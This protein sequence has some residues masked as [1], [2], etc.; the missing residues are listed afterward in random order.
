MPVYGSHPTRFAGL[1][2]D[3]L[4]MGF[5]P[6]T[7]S[8]LTDE[9]RLNLLQEAVN[10]SA[11]AHGEIGSCQVIWDD[12]LQDGVLGSQGNGIIRINPAYYSKDSY[13]PLPNLS[14]S[15]HCQSWSALE[16]VFHEDEHAFQEQAIDGT[17]QI[18]DQELLKQYRSN[19]FD[20]ATVDTVTGKR[21]GLQYISV[22]SNDRRDYLMYYLQSTERDAHRFS[23]EKV[24][25]IMERQQDLSHA[26]T[27]I[28]P[29]I[30][31]VDDYATRI[32]QEFLSANSYENICREA[33]EAFFTEDFEHD[34]NTSL[35][36]SKYGENNPL[37]DPSIQGIVQAAM[38]QSYWHQQEVI[39]TRQT[40]AKDHSA[41]ESEAHLGY[42]WANQSTRPRL[43]KGR[44][45]S[46]GGAEETEVMNL[47][48]VPMSKEDYAEYG[49]YMFCRETMQRPQVEQD[50][51]WGH[52][53][54]MRYAAGAGDENKYI[55][56]RERFL[57][58]DWDC[59]QRALAMDRDADRFSRVFMA[60]EM[61][62][63]ASHSTDSEESHLRMTSSETAD[64]DSARGRAVNEAW[65]READRVREGR[66]TWDWTVEQQAEMLSRSHT[67]NPGVSGFEGSHMLSVKDY[68]EHAGNPDNIQLI[69]SIAHY[70]GVHGR[71]PRANTP[72]GIYN[73]DTGE[74]TPI[75]DGRIPELPVFDLTDR[76][77][78]DQQEFHDAH[79]E[80]EQSGEGRNQGFRETKARHP[81]K[82]IG[83]HSAVGPEAT[84]ET[85]AHRGS[86]TEAQ[87]SAENEHGSGIETEKGQEEP[88]RPQLGD[89]RAPNESVNSAF[90]FE[91]V[92]RTTDADHS[93]N[94][95]FTFT[96]G[97]GAGT[98]VRDDGPAFSTFAFGSSSEGKAKGQSPE[99]VFS[100]NVER[101]ENATE[102]KSTK[103]AFAFEEGRPDAAPK[104]QGSEEGFHFETS[105]H[106]T[107]PEHTLDRTNGEARGNIENTAA[108]NEPQTSQ[109]Q[110]ISY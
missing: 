41:D 102:T 23:Q 1:T 49:R 103:E 51:L 94:E 87:E 45:L 56:A 106:E 84:D 32:Y 22:N 63:D 18:E 61:S 28:S 19:G 58:Y 59:R 109:S 5:R 2:D 101:P 95:G 108:N 80:F 64:L 89:D 57:N 6:T 83:K 36:N 100:F 96:K 70:D 110:A 14:N 53:R 98:E 107:P 47:R 12:S 21:P 52:L 77:E 54:D 24:S 20:T 16:T 93:D 3:Q 43:E 13:F 68:P 46:R 76:Y 29:E 86:L 50:T 69:P 4:Y 74:I 37:T 78:P 15:A 67:S 62:S 99:E 25:A 26:D 60:S 44:G 105:N 7:W 42:D 66:G 75:T 39:S 27:G 9:I 35:V 71:N 90:R 31:A 17:I 34:L 10:R 97:Q 38:N 82:S 92:S 65:E 85:D 81:E 72:N 33:N 11:A 48:G 91:P 88:G 30:M 55:E 73:S 40:E 79:P 8:C 104:K